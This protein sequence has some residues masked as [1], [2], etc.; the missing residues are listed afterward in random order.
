MADNSVDDI[1]RRSFLKQAG[2]AGGVAAG[3]LAFPKAAQVV[4][5]VRPGVQRV[6]KSYPKVRIAR[7]DALKTGEPLDFVY[8]LAQHN[9]F[10]VKLGEAASDGIG[11]DGDIVAFSYICSHMG[12]PLIE[13]YQAAHNVIGPCTCHYSTFDLTKNGILVLGQ[14]TQSLPQVVLET[15]GSHVFAVGVAGLVYGH[16]NNLEGGVPVK[17]LGESS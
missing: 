10:L 8:P 16:S 14:A 2:I 4:E 1:T 17:P 13:Q 9:S 7:L 15:D 5:A 3:I 11:P 6:T 12:C